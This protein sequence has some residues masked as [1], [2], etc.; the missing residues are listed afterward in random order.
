MTRILLIF[1]MCAVAVSPAY[2]EPT[3]FKAFTVKGELSCA[4]GAVFSAKDD[5]I[6]VRVDL[7]EGTF[8]ISRSGDFSAAPAM[9]LVAYAKNETQVNF[10]AVR[11]L[12]IVPD[13]FE[14]TD[15]THVTMTSGKIF[16]EDG[17]PVRLSMRF[18]LMESFET[19]NVGTIPCI[20]ISKFKSTEVIR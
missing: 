1:L 19:P 18:V 3:I 13:I 6:W 9:W 7:D 14:P 11:S 2:A 10:A 16:M 12:P 8:S 17:V 4:D 15:L 5:L 20:E